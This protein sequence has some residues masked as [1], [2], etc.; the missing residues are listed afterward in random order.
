MRPRL[1][2]GEWLWL[3]ALAATGVQACRGQPPADALRL[4]HDQANAVADQLDVATGCHEARLRADIRARVVACPPAEEIQ[5]RACLTRAGT[6]A[7]IDAQGER[8]VLLLARSYH[9]Q[10]RVALS[11]A[12]ACR[13]EALGC[14]GERR[15]EGERLLAQ[16]LTGIPAKVCP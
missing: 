4:A 3:A 1:Y 8:Q 12:A 6:E 9:A 15:T 13:R 16:A 14:E 11:E 7:A 5:R 10:A 2:L